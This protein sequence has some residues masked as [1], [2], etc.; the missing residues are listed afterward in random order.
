MTNAVDR[1]ATA[2]AAAEVA[3][4]VGLE[5]R[6]AELAQ[7]ALEVL[8]ENW[9]GHATKPSPKL[10]PHQWSWDSACHA[11][12]YARFD[13]ERAE[14]ELASL[15][16]G[17]WRNGL[18]PHI[19][20][21]DGQRYF[22]GPEFWQT[23]RSPDAPSRP[24]T[25]GIVQPPIHATAVHEVYRL[26]RDRDR[27]VAFA[28]TM[29]PKLE[30]WHD[31]LYRERTRG[32]ALAEVWHPWETGMDNSPLW[33]APLARIVLA[34]EDVP[35]YRRVDTEL[36]EASQRPTTADYDRYAYLVGVLREHAYDATAI[37]EASPFV[38][39]AVIF[40]SLLVQ[41]NRDLAELARVVGADP[42][43][44]EARAKET[45]AAM[46]DRLWDD[47]AGLYADLDVRAGELLTTP[48]SGAFT[49][50]YAGVPGPE[51]AEQLIGR[52]ESAGVALA[53]Q[54][55]AL[56][57]LPP[58]DPRF[59]P[60]LYWRGPIWPVMNWFLYRGLV[61]YG[62]LELARRVRATLVELPRRSGFWEHYS[63]E[64]G[65]GHGGE[66]FSWTAALMLDA[67]VDQS[68]NAPGGSRAGS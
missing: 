66:R 19:V 3:R 11:I 54:E 60:T 4:D 36:T 43:P 34:P 30:A 59:E 44:H 68:S 16:R 63:P 35:E 15:F 2:G 12:G 58:G 52:L 24:Q 40:N 32:E 10:Y 25:S 45:A 49:P 5:E 39:Q 61:R 23:D 57:S 8:H 46:N 7:R 62:H 41:S 53:E 55:W 26:G 20:F 22:P 18:L 47:A 42:S 51:R 37:R 56:A 14:H 33:D 48:T 31:Y 50:L 27:A 6:D 1:V 17:Q 65:S 28:R 13:Q 21:T 9:I 64:N 38:I 29:V 67:L